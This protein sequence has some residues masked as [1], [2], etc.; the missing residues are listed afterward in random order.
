MNR[1]YY[2]QTAQQHL[3]QAQERLNRAIEQL[4]TIDERDIA[5]ELVEIRRHCLNVETK[6]LDLETVEPISLKEDS[7]HD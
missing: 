5:S 6:L 4:R 1:L 2:L 3:G 7:H